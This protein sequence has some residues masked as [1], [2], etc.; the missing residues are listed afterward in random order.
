M[1]IT[2]RRSGVVGSGVCSLVRATVIAV[3]AALCVTLL[4]APAAQA[5]ASPSAADIRDRIEYLINRDRARYGLRRLRVSTR[6]ESFAKDHAGDMAARGTIFHDVAFSAESLAGATAMGENVGMT[7]SSEPA[8]AAH[9]MFMQSPPHRENVLKARWTHM[10]VGVV[11]RGGYTYVVQRF[12]D[13][14]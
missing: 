10:G 12:A 11:K 3:V 14:G 6:I 7:G 8:R 9:S 4:P 13:A 1:E 2:A 5:A